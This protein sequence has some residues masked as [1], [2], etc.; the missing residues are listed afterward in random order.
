MGA[1]PQLKFSVKATTTGGNNID[2]SCLQYLVRVSNDYGATWDTVM[3]VLP[4]EHVPSLDYVVKNIN[5]SAYAYDLCKVEFIFLHEDAYSVGIN[6]YVDDVVIGTP[7]VNDLAAVSITGKTMPPIGMPSLYTI[8]VKN[9]TANAQSAYTVKL[10]QKGGIE[11]AST[12]GTT[13]AQGETKSFQ[14]A[15]TPDAEIGTYLY[16][17]V[18]MVGDDYPYNNKTRYLHAVVMPASIV[19]I[20]IGTGE[21]G[22]RLPYDFFFNKSLSQTLYFPNDLGTNGGLL[23]ELM[24]KSKFTV[25]QNNKPIQVWI[26]ETDKI[27][28]S[29]GW[30]DPTTL[31][32]IFNG[33]ISI[34]AGPDNIVTIPLSTP[35]TYNGG[36]LV[37]QSYKAVDNA[38]TSTTQVQFYGTM[39]TIRNR[40][41]R[42]L[43]NG[44]TI[45]PMAPD[46]GAET[47]EYPNTVVLMNPA[48]LGSLSGV[49]TCSGAPVEGVKLRLIN[50][51]FDMH[52]NADGTYA[53]PYLKPETYRIEV[54]K[55]GYITDTVD[56]VTIIADDHV[57]KDIEIRT[58]PKFTLSGTVTGNNVAGGL[59][60]AVITLTGY[61]TYTATTDASGY[62]SI[63]DVYSGHAYTV[64][65]TLRDYETYTN[66]ITVNENTTFDI[67]LNEFRYPVFN[68]S[69]AAQGSNTVVSWGEPIRYIEKD[70]VL[71]DGTAEE[72]FYFQSELVSQAFGNK[73]M[74]SGQKGELTGVQVYGANNLDAYG[75]RTVN[76]N[77]YDKSRVLVGESEAFFMPSNRWITVPLNHIPFSDTFYVMVK[78]S[79]GAGWTHGLGFDNNGPNAGKGHGW[80]TNGQSDQIG[81]DWLEMHQAYGIQ[82][83]LFMVRAH[84]NVSGETAG[85]VI[86]SANDEENEANAVSSNFSKGLADYVI[87]RFP[88]NTTNESTWTELGHTAETTYT[89]NTWT[90]LPEGRYQYAV[91]A[92]YDGGF[93][94]E[95]RLTN[96]LSQQT[97]WPFTLNVSANTGDAVTG[98]VVKLTNHDEDIT[99]VYTR[100]LTSNSTTF[101]Q[102]YKGVYDLL[103]TKDGF[104]DYAVQNIDV[105]SNGL[106]HTAVLT[107]TGTSIRPIG[108]QN[109]VPLRAWVQNDV[110][111]INGIPIGQA[112]HIYTISGTLIYQGVAASNTVQLE[113]FNPK[114]GTYIIQSGKQ[115]TK[116]VY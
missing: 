109:I 54:S 8:T 80:W 43:Y 106:T 100:T 39:D 71:D 26:G 67:V 47:N 91:K 98:A 63:S 57:D 60:G 87:Y 89:D 23:T 4:N 115:S 116:V 70:Y 110:L 111:H 27:N 51:L 49:V 52:T 50:Y 15:W 101:L 82:P 78:W 41:R 73:F 31:T 92:R 5:V 6:V 9:E 2:A 112:Y 66:S 96:V 28:L 90:E 53:F 30:V 33:T 46:N 24:Y 42:L 62:Y 94:S 17:E 81:R 21:D 77:V 114:H 10:M 79:V 65:V 59:E 19:P 86:Y 16:G 64:T 38:G 95:A 37:V 99:H 7:V 55:F 14:L 40:T 74:V 69:V 48:G 56:D 36:V 3:R 75:S 104:D 29:N 45:N 93:L 85:K 72:G 68:P 13:I 88:E 103:I 22:I 32:E 105:Y 35:Y 84:A 83:G 20:E 25:D 61:T 44:P 12:A 18:S 1:S 108:A 58:L 11:I 102:V 107:K 34:P 97:Y 76:I 113:N